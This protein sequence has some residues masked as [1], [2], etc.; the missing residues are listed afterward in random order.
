MD[1]W[2]EGQHI[3]S[4]T[5]NDKWERAW[6]VWRR[7]RRL[8]GPERR[9]IVW[10]QHREIGNLTPIGNVKPSEFCLKCIEKW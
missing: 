5:G 8:A 4:Q 9:V 10:D 1:T 2:M 6:C 7:E 3:C